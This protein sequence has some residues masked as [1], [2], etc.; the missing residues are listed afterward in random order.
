MKSSIPVRL[1][2]T[3]GSLT[4]GRWNSGDDFLGKAMWKG[5]AC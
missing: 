2:T 3:R 1:T 4:L 5:P